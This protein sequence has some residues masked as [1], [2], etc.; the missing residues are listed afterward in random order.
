VDLFY[1][2]FTFEHLPDPYAALFEMIR[3]TRPGGHIY[4]LIG[5]LYNSPWGLHAYRTYFA[6]YPQFLLDSA[7]LDRF[8]RENGIY[9]LGTNR[10]SFQYVNRWPFAKYRRWLSDFADKVEIR[11]FNCIT[12]YTALF[13][14][15]RHLECY[16]GRGLDFE[17]LTTTTLEC[18]MR[19]RKAGEGCI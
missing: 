7:T 18:L 14:M 11:K 19:V 6:P 5:P 12:D 4:L 15:Y 17:E 10:D 3:A 13:I 8:V 16:R 9:D 1:S 2:Y